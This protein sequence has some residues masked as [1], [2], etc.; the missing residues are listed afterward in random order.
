MFLTPCGIEVR[1]SITELLM[2][3]WKCHLQE[4][5][6][7]QDMNSLIVPLTTDTFSIITP[8]TF[9]THAHV[10][11]TINNLAATPLHLLLAL[12]TPPLTL[13]PLN[14]L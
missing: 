5:G 6:A 13:P 9:T 1:R 11:A 7:Q 4:E 3:K 10:T 14:V 12:Y 2:D 8:V